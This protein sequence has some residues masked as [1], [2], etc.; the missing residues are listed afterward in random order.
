M[1]STTAADVASLRGRTAL[2]TGA[3]RGIGA[4]IV[5]ALHGAG[6]HVVL[7]GRDI[8]VMTGLARELGSRGAPAPTPFAIDLASPDTVAAVLGKVRSHLEAAPDIVVN[9][10][11]QFLL[12]P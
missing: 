3:S 11:G 6:A 1:S 10:A 5:R 7:L 12:A 9:N 2:V 4:A 8:A